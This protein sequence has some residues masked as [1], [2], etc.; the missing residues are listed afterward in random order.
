MPRLQPVDLAAMKL[1]V[2][3]SWSPAMLH[4]RPGLACPPPLAW[5]RVGNIQRCTGHNDKCGDCVPTGCI[6]YVL[7]HKGA[8]DGNYTPISDD[9]AVSIYSDVTGYVPG[10]SYTDQG[11][12][13]N[14]MFAWWQQN[15]IAGYYLRS[16][17]P[18]DPMNR[19]TVSGAIS[20][21]AACVAC[22]D[23][24]VGQQNQIEW[25]PDGDDSPWG[26]HF[27]CFDQYDGPFSG[28]SWG[29]EQW[30]TWDFFAAGRVLQVWELEI[31]K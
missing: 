16:V 11:T 2:H 30:A 12:N 10:D 31:S 4:P 26:Y 3:K 5:G 19:E 21:F 9:L 15:P 25:R 18:I 23:L 6:N 28:T 29:T 22:V 20:G 7:T 17:V 24:R 27:V 1:G 13:P 14:Q 8:I